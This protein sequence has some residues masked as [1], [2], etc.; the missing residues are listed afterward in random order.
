MWR[1]IIGFIAILIAVGYIL[2]PLDV[3][4]DIIPLIGWIDDIFVGLIGLFMFIMGIR[5]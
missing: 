1:K 3:L 2:W 4:P 5:S